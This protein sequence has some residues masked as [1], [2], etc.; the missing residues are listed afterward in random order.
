M[1][2]IAVPDAFGNKI[3]Y[4]QLV[5]VFGNDPEGQ[6]RYSPAQ[7]L[8]TQCVEVI[9]NPDQKHISNQ[10]LWNARISICGWP[11]AASLA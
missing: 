7:C 9:G 3:D 8:G 11:I 6:K 2:L 1:Y 5:K 4:A 10:F